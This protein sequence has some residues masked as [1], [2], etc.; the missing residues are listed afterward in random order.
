[1][2]RKIVFQRPIFRFHFNLP[3]CT[4]RYIA[5]YVS[6]SPAA[7][8]LGCSV[9]TRA[10]PELETQTSSAFACISQ[11]NAYT[12][13]TYTVAH[14]VIN[15]YQH[16]HGRNCFTFIVQHPLT[17]ALVRPFAFNHPAWTWLL[18]HLASGPLRRICFVAELRAVLLLHLRLSQCI[19][20][21]HAQLRPTRR[22]CM[23]RG[24]RVAGHSHLRSGEVMNPWLG[25]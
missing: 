1:M 22:M 6:A 5:Q 17:P 24:A 4:K 8:Y 18:F 25:G 3:G 10:A 7:T 23:G 16:P 9:K 21:R 11:M 14:L 2:W 15:T 19:L 12:C 20:R 13:W